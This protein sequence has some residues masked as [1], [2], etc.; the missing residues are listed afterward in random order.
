MIR[1]GETVL[2][3]IGS[4]LTRC[5]I[6]E[7]VTKTVRSSTFCL[8]FEAWLTFGSASIVPANTLAAM[9]VAAPEDIT[10]FTREATPAR[11]LC[12]N[13]RNDESGPFLPEQERGSG[14]SHY[15]LHAL[16]EIKRQNFFVRRP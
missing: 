4:S 2:V 7:P 16:I 1:T 10:V 9:R 15:P 6:S 3:P 13:Y 8:R 12:A 11:P 5:G 14:T